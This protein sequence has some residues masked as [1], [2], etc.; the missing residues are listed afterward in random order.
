MTHPVVLVCIQPI[1]I[2]VKT[3]LTFL[4]KTNSNMVSFLARLPS[5]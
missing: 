1:N 4:Y 5:G 2:N 3:Q